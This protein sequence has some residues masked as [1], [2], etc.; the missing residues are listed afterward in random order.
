MYVPFHFRYFKFNSHNIARPA[1]N[2]DWQIYASYSKMFLLP[3]S[4][5]FSM[6]ASWPAEHGHLSSHVLKQP[7]GTCIKLELYLTRQQQVR[8]F[9]DY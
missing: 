3:A 5:P 6:T 7:P 1:L 8:A 9:G 2:V 4:S